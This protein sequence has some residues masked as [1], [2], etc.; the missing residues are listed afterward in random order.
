METGKYMSSVK[1]GPKGQIVIP[2]EVRKRFQI[3]RGDTMLILA[4]AR[5]GLARERYQVFEQ[6][7]DAIFAEGANEF[8]PENSESDSRACAQAVRELEDPKN[9]EEG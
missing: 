8:Y 1:V 2:K 4:E 5:G 7:A 3:K 6:I 9:T